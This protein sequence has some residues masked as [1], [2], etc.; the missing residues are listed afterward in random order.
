[1]LPIWKTGLQTNEW[2]TGLTKAAA[3]NNIGTTLQVRFP[4]GFFLRPSSEYYVPGDLAIRDNVQGFLKTLT[5]EEREEW[6]KKNSSSEIYLSDIKDV[7]VR[8]SS[9][10]GVFLKLNTEDQVKLNSG[11]WLPMEEV[12]NMFPRKPGSKAKKH[13]LI[14]RGSIWGVIDVEEEVEEVHIY[15]DLI[16]C[17]Y[18]NERT[19]ERLCVITLDDEDKTKIGLCDNC[20]MEGEYPIIS[21]EIEEQLNWFTPGILKSLIQKCI[22]MYSEKVVIGENE[23]SNEEVLMTAF[24]M[25]LKNP[26]SFVPDLRAFVRGSESAMKRL[27]VSIIEDSSVSQE[28]ITSLL[29]AALASRKDWKFSEDFI[30]KCCEWAIESLNEGYYEYDFRRLKGKNLNCE[31][32]MICSAIETLGS[33][34]SDINMIK[35]CCENNW[36][37]IRNDCKR[38]EI[39]KIEHCF[40]MHCCTDVIYLL[41]IEKMNPED[42]VKLIW[43]GASRFNPRKHSFELN[44]E[45]EL[46]Q[47]RYWKLM[48]NTFEDVEV[49]GPLLTYSRMLDES[50]IS[51]MIG[52]IEHKIGTSNVSS[53]FHPENVSSIVTIR[54]ATQ[55][56]N[57]KELTDEE[58]EKG[59]QYVI[60]KMSKPFKLKEES[61]GIDC[62]FTFINDKFLIRNNDKILSW[63]DFCNGDIEIVNIGE[64]EDVDFD[65]VIDFISAANVQ[66]VFGNWEKSIIEYLERQPR[67]VI[68]RIS[69]Y[70]RTIGDEIAPYKISRDGK[71]TYL[72]VNWTDAYVFKFLCYCCYLIPVAIKVKQTKSITISFQITNIFIWNNLRKLVFD[73]IGETELYDWNDQIRETFKQM[74][75]KYHDDWSLG[76][77][78]LRVMKDHQR[79]AVDQIISRKQFGKRGNIIWIPVGL[80]KTFIVINV[81]FKL[82]QKKSLAKYVVYALPP[83]AYESVFDEFKKNDNGISI[84]PCVYLDSTQK[85]KKNGNH[86][87]REFHVNFIKHDHLREDEMKQQLID[88]ASDIFL[89]LDEF[90]KMMNVGTQRT[91]ISLELSKICNNFIA[92]TGT[93]ITSSDPHGIIEWVSQVVDFKLTE[94]N[95]MVG[96]AALISNK[97]NHGIE[98]N[99]IFIDVPIEEDHSYYNYVDSRL[100]GNAQETD[101]RKAVNCCYE[102]SEDAIFNV[103]LEVLDN[104]PNVFIVAL[105]KQM[106]SSLESRFRAQG[107]KCFCISSNNSIVMTPGTHEDIQVVITTMQH[108][109]GYTLTAIKTMVLG[110][111]FSNQATRSQ[112]EGRL[113]RMGQLSPV[114]DIITVHCGILSYTLKHYEDTRSLEKALSDLAKEV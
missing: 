22:R 114:V 101:F 59:S 68:F 4:E 64:Y 102:I 75:I 62:Y 94:K 103:A 80:G 57:Q 15:Y 35:S 109:A 65:D 70:L 11:E 1:M 18:S 47:L 69:M 67:E 63:S 2:I 23:Y 78:D 5:Y 38:P 25:L 55:A 37:V 61:I 36:N 58:L 21:E 46:A 27:A 76:D 97:I 99:R 74:K 52:P 108:S 84:L 66:G 91:S 43:D 60:N 48:T 92:M 88:N 85:G 51:G 33:F 14:F 104:E 111:Y 42:A 29:F 41:N 8:F 79:E 89:V 32:N 34:E 87:L 49:D 90:H 95:Y 71:G 98:E 100:G 16:D 9:L 106:Q 19:R 81:L 50:W 83:G 105:N 82:M 26:G 20:Q 12:Y 112:L 3:N 54:S 40:D 72:S 24:L 17:I 45:V 6:L 77:I 10:G 44:K 86:K 56:K 53:F 73:I 96:V 110:V 39:M 107:K 31:H 93:L 113:V 30:F 28:A 7:E 13:T